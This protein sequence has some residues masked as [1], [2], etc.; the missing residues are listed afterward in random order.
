MNKDQVKGE[1]KE[2]SGMIK[3]VAGKIVGNEKLEEKGRIEKT[4]GEAQGA[5]GDIKEDVKEAL[6]KI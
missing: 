2:V 6:K 4:R 1:V 3:E 5:I